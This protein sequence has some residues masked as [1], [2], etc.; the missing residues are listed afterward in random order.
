[1]KKLSVIGA[2][3]LT[4]VIATGCGSKVMTSKNGMTVE[5][6]ESGWKV[7]END[8]G[9]YIL[10]KNNDSIMCMTGESSSI[11]LPTTSEEAQAQVGEG[12]KILEFTYNDSG[13]K[14]AVYYVANITTDNS[15]T[16][17]ISRSEVVGD[18]YTTAVGTA[19]NP[20][21]ERTAE[22]KKKLHFSPYDFE[23]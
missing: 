10:T 7:Q 14:K 20:T 12:G 11:N 4:M 15:T 22:L 2:L 8:E 21:D 17:L 9:T 13:N 19:L 3:L 5:T 1:M 6:P 23:F 16:L 18:K